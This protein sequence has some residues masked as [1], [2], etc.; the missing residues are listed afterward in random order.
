[1]KR[2][3]NENVTCPLCRGEITC[4]RIKTDLVQKGVERMVQ[5]GRIDK[6]TASRIMKAVNIR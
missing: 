6:S 4:I 3:R 2:Q 1:M 5:D